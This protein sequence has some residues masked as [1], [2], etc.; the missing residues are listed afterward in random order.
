MAPADECFETS[1]IP[2]SAVALW[3]VDQ[4]EFAVANAVHDITVF[5]R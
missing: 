2:G 5:Y 3:L 4:E 1:D